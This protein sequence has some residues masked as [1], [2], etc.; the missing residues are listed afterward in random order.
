MQSREMRVSYSNVYDR[1]IMT[2][3]STYHPDPVGY[4]RPPEETKICFDCHTTK[5]VWGE[6]DLDDEGSVF[7]IHCE[8]CHGPGSAHITAV[9]E[10]S[11]SVNILNPRRLPAAEQVEFCGQCH[12]RIADSEPLTVMKREAKLARHAGTGLMLSNCFRRSPPATTISC[13]DCHDPH[14]NVDPKSDDYNTPCRR[15]HTEPAGDHPSTSVEASSNCVSCHM[16]LREDTF[17]G[18]TFTDHWISVPGTE[19]PLFTSEKDDYAGYL[20][21]SYLEAIARPRLG[22]ERKCRFR[23]RL[24]EL[25]FGMGRQEEGLEWIEQALTYGALHR[26]RIVAGE[27][28]EKA[29]KQE[30]ASTI[31]EAAIRLEPHNNRAYHHLARLHLRTNDLEAA[32]QVLTAWEGAIPDDELLVQMRQQWRRQGGSTS[33]ARSGP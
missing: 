16:P 31:F 27:L 28:F 26:D 9:T 30:Q 2:P 15:C 14:R 21:A 4:I 20:E 12:R 18:M 17:A 32:A 6:D 5:L 10:G 1:W 7:G 8:R 23:M 24:G 13:L 3:G 11:P 19:P 22:Q 33:R 29:G 25:L